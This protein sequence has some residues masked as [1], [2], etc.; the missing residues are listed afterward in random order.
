MAVERLV[1]DERGQDLMEYA[2]VVVLIA[3]ATVLA[4][5]TVGSTVVRVLWTPIGPAI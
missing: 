2:L 1:R 3:V 5:G 4:L